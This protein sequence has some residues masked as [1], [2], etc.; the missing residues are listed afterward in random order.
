MILF[1]TYVCN[2]VYNNSTELKKNNITD[3]RLYTAYNEKRE[4]QFIITKYIICTKLKKKKSF[5]VK[6]TK[7]LQT[8]HY[9]HNHSLFL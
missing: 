5:H 8:Q 9:Q 2:V 6:P 3:T 4:K 7:F 1:F